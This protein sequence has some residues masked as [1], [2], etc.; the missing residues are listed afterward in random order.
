MWSKEFRESARQCELL[1]RRA[2]EP[3][4]K[5]ALADLACEFHREAKALEDKE[6]RAS[7]IKRL[8]SKPI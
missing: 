3:F 4:V 5:E 1:A 6:H 8:R 7:V 2:P